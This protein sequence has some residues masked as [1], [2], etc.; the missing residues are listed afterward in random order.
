MALDPVFADLAERAFAG[1]P[2][3]MEGLIRQYGSTVR[4]LVRHRRWKNYAHLRATAG[5]GGV[6][7]DPVRPYA[8]EDRA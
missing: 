5:A 7:A 6:A 8:R 3:A 2:D 4:R 1:D